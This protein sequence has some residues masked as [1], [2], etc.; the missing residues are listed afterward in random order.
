MKNIFYLWIAMLFTLFICSGCM[1][2]NLLEN[3]LS[4]M[5]E[6]EKTVKKEVWN[7]LSNQEKQHIIGAWE[8][9]TMTKT[10]LHKYNSH[11]TN[12]AYEGETVYLVHFPSDTAEHLN[13]Y[14]DIETNEIIGYN[15]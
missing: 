2:S 13:V 14:V 1:S 3:N 5:Y 10:V 15:Q 6:A 8:H 12:E 9:A 11:E 7:Q 4:Q